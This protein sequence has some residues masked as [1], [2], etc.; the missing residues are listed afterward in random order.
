MHP[1]LDIRPVRE[2]QQAYFDLLH[3]F[4]GHP[5]EEM[6]KHNLL[7]EQIASGM[8][9][10]DSLVEAF[11]SERVELMRVFIDFWQENRST[12]NNYLRRVETMKSFF[13]GD[14]SPIIDIKH[15]SCTLLYTDTVVLQCPVLRLLPLV[16]ISDPKQSL[17]LLVKHSLNVMRFRELALAEVEPP[18]LLMT[19]A[20]FAV[21]EDYSTDLIKASQ[22]YVLAHAKALLGRD[23]AD[24]GALNQYLATLRSTSEVTNAIAD[25]ERALFDTEWGGTLEEQVRRNAEDLKVRIG[26]PESALDPGFTL[27]N[28]ISGRM[29]QANETVLLSSSI[30]ASPLISAPTSWQYLLWRYEYDAKITHPESDIRDLLIT[31]AI[32]SR[33]DREEI[34]LLSGL[35][36]KSIVRLRREGAIGSIRELLRNALNR[37]DLASPQEI[38]QVFEE[39][40][41]EM[42]EAFS[43]H[44]RELQDLRNGKKRFYGVDVASSVA[45]GILTIAGAAT[46]N[47]PLTTAGAFLYAMLGSKSV[48]VLKESWKN[49][50]TKDKE[51]KRS[52]A[53]VLL[54]SLDM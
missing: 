34:P 36:V 10:K 49:L 17:R 18:I 6:I 1:L 39:V 3:R 16:S 51:I 46:G 44:E 26:F 28:L 30:G 19:G 21:D 12:V 54:R 47:I 9:T 5:F 48:L 41:R 25:S 4:F 53:A 29:I 22:P 40:S 14:I 33:G 38:R 7:P 42:G 50:Q 15:F 45:G 35:S 37:I 8:S 31:N 43:R 11:D 52:P 13:G 20:A 2:I 32:L 27:H 23:F 24:S